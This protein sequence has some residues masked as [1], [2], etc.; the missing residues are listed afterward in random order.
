MTRHR[1]IALIAS[2]DR[3][4]SIGSRTS[5]LEYAAR[6]G[7]LLVTDTDDLVLAAAANANVIPLSGGAGAL[8]GDVFAEG[9]A[10]PEFDQAAERRITGSN[11][12]CLVTDCWGGYLAIVRD[13]NTG[14]W[15]VLR[16]PSGATPCYYLQHGDTVAIASDTDL[17]LEAG[18]FSPKIDWNYVAWSLTRDDLRPPQ[19]A[20][21]NLTELI[22]GSRLTVHD[23][24]VTITQ[25][26]SPWDFA[27]P[28]R[29]IL[30]VRVARDHLRRAAGRAISGWASRFNRIVLGLSGGLDSSIV[31]AGL[32]RSGT[33]FT[34]LTLV[35][36]DAS[37]DERHYARL[38]TD[39]C[40]C[41][42]VEA[43]RDVSRIDL[44]RSFAAHLPRPAARSFAQESQRAYL[45]LARDVG[46]DALFNGGGGDNV[47]CYLQSARPVADRVLVEGLG[48]NA[49]AS[50]KDMGRLA[51]TSA[52][53]VAVQAMRRAWFQ[54]PGYHWRSNV[55][56][57]D[58]DAANQVLGAYSHPWLAA[59]ARALPG[60]AA[61]IALLLGIQNHLD[62]A[63]LATGSAISTVSPL[64]AQ[65]LVELCL[66]IPSWMWCSGGRN[67]AVARDAFADAL[68][69]AIIDRRS[70]G[71]PSTFLAEIFEA[72]RGVIRDML[73]G[74][75]LADH[76]L[77]DTKELD[78]FLADPRPS[79]GL[80]FSRIL[81]LVDV[82]A[83]ARAWAGKTAS[84]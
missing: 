51:D 25:L 41:R 35:T 13:A 61:H 67:R 49:W 17:L 3:G 23:H 52:I 20:L 26:W 24:Q 66:R 77:L 59:P 4:V 14:R 54:K 5:L 16:D 22:G 78:R 75:L 53:E 71:S 81:R 31:A 27:D 68:P 32:S 60:K 33:S 48:A 42:L 84:S 40:R 70:K 37:G 7:L 44:T 39:A 65:P 34:C 72:N 74:G 12:S 73:L 10:Q 30:D 43:V 62:G 6:V 45:S 83:W 69:A 2:R 18:L 38:V 56:F 55:E 21:E 11:G 28:G 29:Q 57:L 63:A 47:F 8:I 76:A 15:H 36:G 58:P 82:E 64:M 46:A 50:A 1:Y 80:S 19:T 9:I 79:H